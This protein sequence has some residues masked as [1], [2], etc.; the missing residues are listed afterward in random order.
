MQPGS[1]CGEYEGRS[2][3]RAVQWMDQ[4]EGAQAH[5]GLDG[6]SPGEQGA[7]LKVL[8]SS[9]MGKDNCEERKQYLCPLSHSQLSACDGF[10]LQRQTAYYSLAF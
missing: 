4:S 7:I 1:T 8:E 3:A 5:R 2:R 9:W 10:L 6:S